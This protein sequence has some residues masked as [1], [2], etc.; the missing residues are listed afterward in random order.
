MARHYDAESRSDKHYITL[1]D[2]RKF[3]V[4]NILC[5]S[6][7]FADLIAKTIVEEDEGQYWEEF[8][9]ETENT[10]KLLKALA[11]ALFESQR[12]VLL[13]K[14][15]T[16]H[17]VI[18][19]DRA[20]IS[21][22]LFSFGLIWENPFLS[23]FLNPMIQ[24][25]V[26]TGKWAASRMGVNLPNYFSTTDP[27]LSRQIR[28]RAEL[29]AQQVVGTTIE[30][31]KKTWEEGIDEE[32]TLDDLKER[33]DEV[34]DDSVENRAILIARNETIWAANAGILAAYIASGVIQRKFWLTAKDEKTCGA[35]R[36]MGKKY[37][38]GT[39]GILVSQNFLNKGDV[40]TYDDNGVSKSL[41]IEY[42]DIPHPP[43]HIHCRCVLV[44][45]TN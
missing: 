28:K 19:R 12:Q 29:L 38:P 7:S 18:I 9:Q 13:E 1:N 35:C 36:A 3:L 33:V 5:K 23:S 27:L 32:E 30:R 14:M 24:V 42:D 43:L 2:K 45:G 31:L 17:N 37:G 6:K 39:Q 4:F 22:W 44:P 34:F 11:V 20:M 10:E 16:D 8:I 15:G 41:L 40:L 25:A 21:I 26:D